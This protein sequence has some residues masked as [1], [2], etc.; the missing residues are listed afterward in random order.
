MAITTK[1]IIDS[2]LNLADNLCNNLKVHDVE[3]ANDY[4]E[5][6]REIEQTVIEITGKY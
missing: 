6:I 5:Q 4:E 3:M 1:Q 2:L